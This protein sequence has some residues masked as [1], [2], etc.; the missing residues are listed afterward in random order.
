MR[1]KLERGEH[2]AWKQEV[3]FGKI[4]SIGFPEFLYGDVKQALGNALVKI[5]QRVNVGRE[6]RKPSP[7]GISRATSGNKMSRTGDLE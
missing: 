7:R 4:S 1:Q 2:L 6:I 5:R 3:R